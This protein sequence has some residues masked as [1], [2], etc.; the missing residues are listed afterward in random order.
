MF[1]RLESKSGLCLYSI[2]IKL[3]THKVDENGELEP[4]APFQLPKNFIEGSGHNSQSV[5][6]HYLRNLTL[7]KIEL[8]EPEKNNKWLNAF[9]CE[10]VK[11]PQNQT[12]GKEIFCPPVGVCFYPYG[13]RLVWAAQK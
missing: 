9:T 8:R 11:M 5:T 2:S 7:S 13:L 6:T 1:D 4:Y 3:N 10:K 12:G